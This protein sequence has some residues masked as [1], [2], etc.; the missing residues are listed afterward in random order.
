MDGAARLTPNMASSQRCRSK[1]D[2]GLQLARHPVHTGPRGGASPANRS[3]PPQTKKGDERVKQV[4]YS[5]PH[6][7]SCFHTGASIAAATKRPTRP[8]QSRHDASTQSASSAPLM[9][10]PPVLESPT[11]LHA[12]RHAAPLPGAACAS[13]STIRNATQQIGNWR[14]IAAWRS[15]PPR[16]PSR[17]RCSA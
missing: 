13:R 14:V 8:P 15:V 9:K 3:R 12:P 10:M 5:L 11:R 17:R 16:R 1:V 2:F 4:C 6:R 7:E